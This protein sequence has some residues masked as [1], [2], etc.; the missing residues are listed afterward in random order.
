MPVRIVGAKISSSNGPTGGI[1][2][3]LANWNKSSSCGLARPFASTQTPSLP[4]IH[5]R[6]HLRHQLPVASVIRRFS[7]GP[8]SLLKNATV[9][10][11]DIDQL[12]DKSQYKDK[13]EKGSGGLWTL[14]EDITLFNCLLE[15]QQIVDFY[16]KFPGR[17]MKSTSTRAYRLRHACFVPPDKGGVAENSDMPVTQRVEALRRIM[18][19]YTVDQSKADGY[20]ATRTTSKYMKYAPEGLRHPFTE[21]EKEMLVK[22][23]YKYR[24]SPD[25]WNMV[26]GGGLVDEEGA[27]RLNRSTT[28]CKNAWEAMNRSESIKAGKWDQ[29]EHRKLLE[30]VRGQVGDKYEICFGV[31][32]EGPEGSDQSATATSESNAKPVLTIRSPVLQKLNWEK[33]ANEVH[34]R[35]TRQCREHFY[36]ALHNGKTWTWAD[37]EIELLLE[38]YKLYGHQW[39]KVSAHIGTRSKDQA[40]HKYKYIRMAAEKSKNKT[41]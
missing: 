23:V 5:N 4:W 29:N 26:S 16:H 35:T 38:G 36:R 21:E 17:T 10:T 34:T 37:K 3:L 20:Y 40:I 32:G 13:K 2:F 6:I 18:F 24:N 19:K 9:V 7:L 28:S 25:M 1:P 15:N 14:E 31:K 22:L 41:D 8:S 39:D 27:P 11:G 30:A 33:I 12:Q